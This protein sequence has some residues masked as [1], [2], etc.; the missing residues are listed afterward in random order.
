[1]QPFCRFAALTLSVSNRKQFSS[2][3]GQVLIGTLFVV[4][5]TTSEDK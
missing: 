3:A 4:S 1:M 2:R 5:F